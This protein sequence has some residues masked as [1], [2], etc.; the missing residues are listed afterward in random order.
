MPATGSDC[1][2]P[3]LTPSG[4]LRPRKGCSSYLP[5]L[6]TWK[7]RSR[8]PPFSWAH[9]CSVSGLGFEQQPDQ[10]QN[11]GHLQQE[12]PHYPQV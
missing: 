1:P 8:V 10:V 12:L 2:A 5:I 7:P 9:S 11:L 6:Q 3:Y 4:S